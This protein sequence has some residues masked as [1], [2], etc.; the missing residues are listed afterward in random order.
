MA[1]GI[2]GGPKVFY[3]LAFKKE[4][5]ELKKQVKKR[6]K[7]LEMA[8]ANLAGYLYGESRL[9]KRSEK[10]IVELN[11]LVPGFPASLEK[12]KRLKLKSRWVRFEEK[13]TPIKT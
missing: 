2:L 12:V 3:Y 6:I 5:K 9:W 1:N 10:E 11:K 4:I 8:R 7:D 13:R